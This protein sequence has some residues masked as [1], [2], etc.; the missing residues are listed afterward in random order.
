M[1]VSIIKVR[2]PVADPVIQKVKPAQRLGEVAGKRIGLYWNIKAGGDLALTHV[3]DILS[4]RYPGTRF[5]YY[6]GD[7][8]MGTRHCTPA[9]AERISKEVD[10]VVGTSA[11]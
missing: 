10:A 1:D 3:D 9:Q 7:V 11:D 6:Q 5:T 4:K 8:G 2:N